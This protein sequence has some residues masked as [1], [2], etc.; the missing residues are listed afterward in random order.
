VRQRAIREKGPAFALA[1][2][3]S[4]TAW[5]ARADDVDEAVAAEMR[6]HQ[7]T[8]LSLAVIDRGEIVKAK[9]YGST[10]RAGT[11]AVTPETLFQ[12]GSVSKSLAALG[13]L[14]LVEQG[15]LSLDDDVNLRLRTWKVP[16]N[17]FTSEKKVTLREILSHTAGFTVHGFRGYAAGEPLPTLVQVLDGLPPAN[18]KP[19]R[20]DL[21]P[22]KTWRYSGGG[23]IV[24]QQLVLDVTGRAFPDFMEET[25][26]KPLGMTNSS[27][28]QPLPP[29][30]A[31]RMATGYG[32]LRLA[33]DGGAHVYPE[34][35]AAGLWTTPSDLARFAISIQL[36]AAGKSNPVISHRMT[37]RMLTD[38]KNGDGLGVFLIG[39]AGRLWFYHSGRNDGFDAEV[40]AGVETGQGV[41][42]MINANDNSG[43]VGRLERAVA[44][45]YGWFGLNLE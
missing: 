16:E 11:N 44:R 37:L 20:V 38:Q 39:L 3:L 40:R 2:I 34:M 23:Y 8:G 5:A 26:L 14:W 42:V 25:V 9:G 29:E 10:D 7:I 15:K 41:V 33:V 4:A 6:D 18:N 17:E 22:K 36:A 19:I 21:T 43:V 31:A 27:Y 1:F 45:H 35:A 30:R 12:A 28:A 24:M 13:A 32:E